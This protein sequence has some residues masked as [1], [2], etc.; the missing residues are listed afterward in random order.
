MKVSPK[1]SWPSI[2][3]GLSERSER[4]KMN[5][6]PTTSECPLDQHGGS[7]QRREG[8]FVNITTTAVEGKVGNSNNKYQW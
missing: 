1:Q 8:E 3:P 2:Q 6:S 4:W 5:L 7:E